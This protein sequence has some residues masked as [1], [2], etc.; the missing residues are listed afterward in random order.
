MQTRTVRKYI[1]IGVTI[2]ITVSTKYFSILK[3]WYKRQQNTL[4]PIGG[5]CFENNILKLQI[6][7]QPIIEKI[8]RPNLW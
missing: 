6:G 1:G 8:S 7:S 2:S 5:L 4:Y 3:V